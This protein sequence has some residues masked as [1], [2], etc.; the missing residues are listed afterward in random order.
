V[1]IAAGRGLAEYRAA[2][3]AAWAGDL[4]VRRLCARFA[5]DTYYPEVGRYGDGECMRAAEAVFAANSAVAIAQ[6]RHL[7]GIDPV[8]LTVLGML[9]IAAAFS[10]G[11]EQGTQ[12]LAGRR[13][14][15]GRAADRATAR[16][17]T[18]LARNGDRPDQRADRP[19][20]LP[21]RPA[22]VGGLRDDSRSARIP[23]RARRTGLPAR[24]V[25]A[26]LVERHRPRGHTRPGLT[27]GPSEPRHGTRR[28]WHPR[29][30]IGRDESRACRS[31]ATPKAVS[32]LCG[33]FDR[34][35]QGSSACPWWPPMIS[36]SE[37]SQ[38]RTSQ[39]RQARPS[40]CSGTP[41]APPASA[42]A[43]ARTP[44]RRR[45]R[46]GHPG[47]S[48]ASSTA[49]ATT[50]ENGPLAANSR[51]CGPFFSVPPCIALSRCKPLCRGVH[52]RMVDGVRAP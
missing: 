13:L 4:C 17:A 20:G 10:G 9:D 22:R 23:R 15:P 28:S 32:E 21:P 30:T 42:P 7:P 40:W 5:L 2:A 44:A 11:L 39:E 3:L 14:Q 47:A 19:R 16:T 25:P 37:H 46:T 41:T 50:C 24:R 45:P 33:A 29:T 51:L 35:R 38:G 18:T 8:A 36:L 43:P 26:R 31:K 49:P 1:R 27:H 12:W 34:Y 6:L 52:E 48:P